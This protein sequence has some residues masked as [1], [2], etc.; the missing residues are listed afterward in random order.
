[1]KRT[2]A[3]ALEGRVGTDELGRHLIAGLLMEVFGGKVENEA[4]FQD[5]VDQVWVILNADTSSRNLVRAAL[6]ELVE[7]D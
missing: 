7:G 3:I 6:A 5:I 4:A 2:K 1:M